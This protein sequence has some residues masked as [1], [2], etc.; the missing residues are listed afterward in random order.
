MKPKVSERK[1]KKDQSRNNLNEIKKTT[2]KIS[3]TNSPFFEKINKI[4]KSSGRFTEKNK[5]IQISKVRNERFTVTTDTTE[6]K[7]S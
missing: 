5:R 6:Y 4:D 3:E 1:K 2:E 7:R